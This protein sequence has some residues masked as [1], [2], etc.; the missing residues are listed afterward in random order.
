MHLDDYSAQEI[1]QICRNHAKRRK[2]DFEDG[3][4]DELARHIQK[5]HR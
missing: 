3:L 1:A 4:V 5:F 2:R